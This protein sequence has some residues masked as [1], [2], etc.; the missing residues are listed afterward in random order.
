MEILLPFTEAAIADCRQHL[1]QHPD[2]DPVISAYLARYVNGLMC[3]EI[4]QVVSG[5]IRAR[6]EKGCSDTATFNFLKSLQRGVVRN[7]KIGEIKTTIGLLGREYRDTFDNLINRN[8]GD[9]GIDRLGRAVSERNRNAH[10]APPDITFG[11]LEEV[12]PFA[13][14]VVEAVRLTLEPQT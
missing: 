3:A 9:E 8:V 14:K 12:I 2:I 4:E 11:E 7:A 10:D 1:N 6:L 5:L 13:K